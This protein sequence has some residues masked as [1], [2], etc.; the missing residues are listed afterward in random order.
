MS[1]HDLNVR[2]LLCQ[3]NQFLEDTCKKHID[4]NNAQNGIYTSF[5]SRQTIYY[6]TFHWKW[7]LPILNLI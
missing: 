6:K 4:L 1:E 5:I 3:Y 2:L 7:G